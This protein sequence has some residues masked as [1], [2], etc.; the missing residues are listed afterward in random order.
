MPYKPKSSPLPLTPLAF[1]ILMA[2]SDGAQHGYGIL[3]AVEAR[4][5]GV[6]PLRTGTLYRALARLLEDGLIAEVEA[7]ATDPRR[8]HYSLTPLGRSVATAE[9]ERLASQVDAARAHRLLPGRR[10]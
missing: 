1:E 2:L 4:L 6:L 5:A 10:S 9:A 3:Q 8:R 7:A